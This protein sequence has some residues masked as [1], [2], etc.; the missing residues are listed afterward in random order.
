MRPWLGCVTWIGSLAATYAQQLRARLG[1]SAGEGAAVHDD[2]D[3]M[4]EDVQPEGVLVLVPP[5][6]ATAV[7]ER[8]A[9]RRAAFLTEKPPAPDTAAHRR[10][11]E[12]VGELPHV[13]AYNRRHAPYIRQAKEWMAGQAVQSVTVLFSRYRRRDPD[14]TTTVCA[15]DRHGVVF[16]GRGVRGDT[17]GGG[18]GG[19]G[20]QLIS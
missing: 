4:L 3:R 13:V 5:P 19:A 10:L 2:L 8:V 12:V 6:V 17:G 1:I 15:C 9:K 16:G 18:A 14:F 7:I 11:I 20:D